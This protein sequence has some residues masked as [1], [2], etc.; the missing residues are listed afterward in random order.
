[1]ER[2]YKYYDQ[3]R[4][5][6]TPSDVA[7]MRASFILDMDRLYF[8]RRQKALTQDIYMVNLSGC[9]ISIANFIVS[10]LSTVLYFIN[11]LITFSVLQQKH[12]R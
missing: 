4:Y 6:S 1:M 5:T 8:G 10:S 7:K 3:A 9:S 12:M 11:I 2:F